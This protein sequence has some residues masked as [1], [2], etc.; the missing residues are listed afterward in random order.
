MTKKI[1]TIVT[2]NHNNWHEPFHIPW[3]DFVGLT[4]P[5]DVSITK[6]CFVRASETWVSWNKKLS[7]GPSLYRP[8]SAAV[9]YKN[10]MC[11]Y[12]YGHGDDFRMKD[13]Q[14]FYSEYMVTHL[15]MW[16][17]QIVNLFFV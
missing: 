13:P 4:N 16:D 5:F 8:W 1:Q 17:K 15:K 2:Q 6:K 14:L 3:K 7:E 10:G 9:I 12:Q 11:E